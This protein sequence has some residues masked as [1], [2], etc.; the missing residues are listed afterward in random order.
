MKVL[1]V[2][3]P[4][5]CIRRLRRPRICLC[6]SFNVGTMTLG[7][8]LFSMLAAGTAVPD[9]VH[10]QKDDDDRKNDYGTN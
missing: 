3:D 2:V 8:I 4:D 6:S 1:G 9:D 5:D 10:K 7:R